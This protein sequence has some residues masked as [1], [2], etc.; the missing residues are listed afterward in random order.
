[1]T[2]MCFD[3][4]HIEFSYSRKKI[5]DRVSTGFRKKCFYGIL[6]PNGCGKTT[7]L[8]LLSGHRYA[9]KGDVFFMG[10]TMKKISKKRLSRHIALVSQ[11]FYINFPY[12]VT[13]VV[14]MGRYPHLSRFSSPSETDYQI[15]ED[16]MRKT[17]VEKFKD[18]LITELSGGERQ[19]TVFARALAQNTDV[20]LLDE[21]TSNLDI[22]HSLSLLNI[23]KK[24]V[25]KKNM[26]VISVFQDINLA[27][28]FCD[29][30][31]F[32][33]QGRIIAK[34]P[35]HEMMDEKILEDVFR[36]RSKI[37]FESLYNAKQAVFRTGDHL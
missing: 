22:S 24:G 21:A 11:N 34:G 14:M 13:D 32:M 31:V 36:V 4:Q 2:D 8:D 30:M 19:R 37:R 20:L 15:V 26:T 10:K 35:T 5:I 1:M 25:L 28:V 29:E 9:D 6:G 7:F 3:V 12:T 18:N 23:V 33:K 17:E 27:A 16:V